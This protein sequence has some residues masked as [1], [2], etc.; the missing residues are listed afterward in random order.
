MRTAKIGPDLRLFR[1]RDTELE[2]RVSCRN[3]S[4]F[5]LNATHHRKTS[6]RTKENENI[7]ILGRRL[8]LACSREYVLLEISLNKPRLHDISKY[9]LLAPLL[10]SN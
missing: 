10:C 9:G 8:E 6:N 5:S 4:A 3:L 2:D 1:N 7:C